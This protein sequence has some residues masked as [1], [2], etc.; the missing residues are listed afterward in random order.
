MSRL[1]ASLT[2]AVASLRY[3]QRYEFLF[4]LSDNE[5]RARG[6]DRDGLVQSFVAGR[7]HS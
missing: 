3:A 6:L 7:A 2:S 5:L 1:I 4:S